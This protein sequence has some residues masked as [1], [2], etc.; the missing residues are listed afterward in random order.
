MAQVKGLF[1]NTSWFKL[2]DNYS[3]NSYKFNFHFTKEVLPSIFPPSI[4]NFF[5]L[6]LSTIYI[7]R[8]Y[9]LK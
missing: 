6:P 2:P 1:S 7:S 5:F 9:Y 8:Q 3:G 4:K